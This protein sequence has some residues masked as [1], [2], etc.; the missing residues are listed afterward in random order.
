MKRL[1]QSVASLGHETV[2]WRVGERC[3]LA[4]GAS[5]G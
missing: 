3:V 4:R 2:L 1:A 5:G